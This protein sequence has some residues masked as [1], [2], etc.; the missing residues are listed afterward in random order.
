MGPEPAP[1]RFGGDFAGAGS[2]RCGNSFGMKR[3]IW[4]VGALALLACRLRADGPAPTDRAAPFSLPDQ[5]GALVSL[6][7]LTRSGATVLVFYRGHW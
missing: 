4:L 2:L 5:D 7:S 1:A 6:D 3:R